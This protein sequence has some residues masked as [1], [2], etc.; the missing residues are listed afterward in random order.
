M[1][2][3]QS[4]RAARL[5]DNFIVPQSVGPR[6]P[7]GDGLPAERPARFCRSGRARPT[8]SL[9]HRLGGGWED[10]RE[11]YPGGGGSDLDG[12]PAMVRWPTRAFP[13]HVCLQDGL[14]DYVAQT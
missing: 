12:P 10:G 8:S 6:V 1:S 7:V 9:Y 5:G 3:L 4:S 11:E 2:S 14:C 13:P